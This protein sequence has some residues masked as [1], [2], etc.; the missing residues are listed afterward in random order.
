MH[1]KSEWNGWMSVSCWEYH[2]CACALLWM[3][4]L[5]FD[6]WRV[7]IVDGWLLLL[8]FRTFNTHFQFDYNNFSYTTRI[9][10][11]EC[12]H[13]IYNEWM[14]EQQLP[15]WIMMYALWSI[16]YSCIDHVSRNTLCLNIKNK[17]CQ[18]HPMSNCVQFATI[19][20]FVAIFQQ[21]RLHCITEYYTYWNNKYNLH[22]TFSFM[23][24]NIMATIRWEIVRE[25][26]CI[27]LLKNAHKQIILHFC[28]DVIVSNNWPNVE[29][30]RM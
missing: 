15:K 24:N 14:S 3:L 17:I 29:R 4:W 10:Y 27:N 18:K 22:F 7:F 23:A 8:A 19:Y 12:N 20:H 1:A 16:V 28:V 6:K 30:A 13:F 9:A 5:C 11:L 25:K 26:M 21:V 2:M